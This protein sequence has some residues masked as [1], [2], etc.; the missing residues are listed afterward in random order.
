MPDERTRLEI[1]KVH[2]KKMPLDKD[3]DLRE[4]AK[5]TEG[6]TGADIEGICREAGMHA[7]RGNASKVEKTHFEHALKVTRPTVT[8]ERLEGMKK[9]A[10]SVNTMYG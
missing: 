8:K 3:I 5:L 6:H 10:E 1:F 9:F 2:T 4:F 7:I